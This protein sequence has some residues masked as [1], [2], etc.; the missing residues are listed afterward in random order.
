MSKYRSTMVL[1]IY[2]T[3]EKEAENE[4]LKKILYVDDEILEADKYRRH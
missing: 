2:L 1:V 4:A 3:S